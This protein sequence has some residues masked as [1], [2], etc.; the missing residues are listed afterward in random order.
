MESILQ[1]ALEAIYRIMIGGEAYDVIVLGAK[2]LMD[3]E[4]SN[5]EKRQLVKD[6][7]MPI[8][9]ELGKTF[10]SAIIAFAVSSIKAE[11]TK[12]ETVPDNGTGIRYAGR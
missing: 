7:V 8:A 9:K 4:L 3:E 5:D 2:A 10:L 1:K 6:A 11:M 12:E